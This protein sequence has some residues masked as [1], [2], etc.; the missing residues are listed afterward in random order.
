[1]PRK[2]PKLCLGEASGG[3]GGDAAI[4]PVDRLSA[5]PDELLHRVLSFL[6][7]W[8]VARTCVLA[9]RWR[10]LWA[11]APCVDLRVWRL[12]RHRAPPRRFARFVYRFFIEREASAPVDTLRLLSS[13]VYCV[14]TDDDSGDSDTDDDFSD[15]EVEWYSTHDVDIWVRAAI[16]RKARVIQ[17]TDHPNN[18][19]L[20]SFDRVNMISCHLKHLKLSGLTLRDQTMMQLSSQWC[21][22][23][24]V[25]DLK[26]CSLLGSEISSA[27]LKSLSMVQCRITTE[28]TISA[29]NL[30]S[31]R[32]VTPHYR[33]PLFKNLV[34]LATGVVVLADSFLHVGY[35]YRDIDESSADES[36]ESD[37]SIGNDSDNYDSDAD[38]NASTCEYSEIANDY[39]EKQC[40][41][42]GD[43][44]NHSK[45]D[46]YHG[47]GRNERIN[48]NKILG[49]HNVLH[50][51][52][53][54]TSLELLAD[55][56]EVIL[57]KELKTC[58]TFS[59]LKTLSLGEWCMAAD[60]DP[61]V[62]FLQHTPNLERLYLGLKLEYENKEEMEDS[63]RPE[64]RSLACTNLKMVKIKCSKDDIRVHLLAQLFRANGLPVENIYVRQT[65]RT[66]ISTN[67]RQHEARGKLPRIGTAILIRS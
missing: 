6:R 17:L 54:A 18:R 10:H 32:C 33:V 64:G 25:L 61:L 67:F 41:D 34:S 53:K 63:T 5:L 57:N 23:L 24:E 38:S 66:S 42:N 1:M 52:S 28:L 31:L 58:P 46:N 44:H 49:R 50:G 27:S 14:D 13:P 45:H 4:A 9:R 7:A 37:C 22:A 3:G 30:V 20:Y 56:G 55:A 16:K 36:S 11:S 51:L 43:N 62:C 35:E 59:N 29:T 39:E 40:G 26:N 8:E 47:Y 19:G 21:P 2:K 15:G 12:G 65:R 60:F 48:A